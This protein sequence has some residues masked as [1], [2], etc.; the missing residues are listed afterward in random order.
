MATRNF[1]DQTLRQLK[2]AAKINEDALEEDRRPGETFRRHLVHLSTI[3]KSID[4]EKD[5]GRLDEGDHRRL[6]REAVRH[7][8]ALI[9]LCY[10]EDYAETINLFA[11][12]GSTILDNQG[13][14]GRSS[15]PA[16]DFAQLLAS[17]AGIP[18]PPSQA[19]APPPAAS[20]TPWSETF[21]PS[22]HSTLLS[23]FAGGYPNDALVQLLDSLDPAADTGKDA[24]EAV[25]QARASTLFEPHHEVSAIAAEGDLLVYAG[26]GGWKN[27]LDYLSVMDVPPLSPDTTSDLLS[28]RTLRSG[29]GRPGRQVAYNSSMGLVW[30]DGDIRLRAYSSKG[31]ITYTLDCREHEHGWILLNGGTTIVRGGEKGLGIWNVS[32]LTRHDGKTP[33]GGREIPA[34]D[35]EAFGWLDPGTAKKLERSVGDKPH[36]AATVDNV[37]SDTLGHLAP[38]P[39]APQKLLFARREGPDER[40][41]TAVYTLDLE[42]AAGASIVPTIAGIGHG[43]TVT[44]LLTHDAVPD[45]FATACDD[46]YVRLY[47]YRHALPQIILKGAKTI[48]TAAT[49]SPNCGVAPLLF[50]AAG[51]QLVRAWDVR[52]TK[53]GLYQLSTG[54]MDVASLAFHDGFQSLFVAGN[55]PPTKYR[56]LREHAGFRVGDAEMWPSDA[57]HDADYFGRRWCATID[58]LLEYRFRPVPGDESPCWDEPMPRW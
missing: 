28:F 27:R 11:S 24:V 1:V 45:L 3:V 33:V 57:A 44:Q 34:N 31:K 15:A 18:S 32:Q 42:H 43:G 4:G 53:Q 35:D 48:V 58:G 52:Q 23:R 22:T 26:R 51:D 19:A 6:I 46:E 50:T 16:G 38:V 2:K 25:L 47:D 9:N 30:H 8:D 37:P 20:G 10:N 54:T 21:R 39:N 5:A 14:R 49:F 29:L 12:E 41:D 55:V 7:M 40:T 56:R 13:P 36:A 17:L